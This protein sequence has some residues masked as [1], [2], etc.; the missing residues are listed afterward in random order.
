MFLRTLKVSILFLFL[1]TFGG[2][3][4]AIECEDL[5]G[6]C[7]DLPPVY[8]TPGFSGGSGGGVGGPG[9]GGTVPTWQ[10]D[11]WCSAN[12]ETC[13]LTEPA[14]F[15]R[16]N[17]AGCVNGV[18]TSS[19]CGPGSASGCSPNLQITCAVERPVQKGACIA[20]CPFS[21]NPLASCSLD[22]YTSAGQPSGETLVC[23]NTFDGWYPSTCN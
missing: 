9:W 5:P 1:M 12:L 8:V 3:A 7:T 17:P 18:P 21:I 20:E 13:M 15:C 2:L 10:I 23:V 22:L 14:S 16:V 4:N 6:G 19:G 11:A